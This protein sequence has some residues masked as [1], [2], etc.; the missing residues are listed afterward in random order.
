MNIFNARFRRHAF[1]SSTS[2]PKIFLFF[3][4]F[5]MSTLGSSTPTEPKATGQLQQTARFSHSQ[6]TKQ[7]IFDTW[8]KSLFQLS[9]TG[10]LI[11]EIKDGNKR[12]YK[13]KEGRYEFSRAF[14]STRTA[15]VIM[16]P[17]AD[18]GS[19]KLNRF[20][21]K[22]FRERL[23]PAVN[24]AL[25]LGF[26]VIVLTND[27]KRHDLAYGAEISQPLMR[28]VKKGE[29]SILYHIDHDDRTFEK[30]LKSRHIES[31]IYVG[32]ASNMCVIGMPMG[33][34]P[35]FHRGF[36]LFYI[37]EASAAFEFGDSWDTGNVHRQ[38]TSLIS[39]WVAEIINFQDFIKVKP[40]VD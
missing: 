33:M 40:L 32:F 24:H 37:P 6:S 27:P 15:L 31:L 19:L 20:Y 26:S 38:T 18:S 9:D 11:P 39:Q 1:L 13:I 28:L 21:E 8:K 4:A 2:H 3:V 12:F 5:W 36:K 23:L 30:Y 29:I 7:Y 34:I 25:K 17:W 14:V 16:D 22:V 35:M 10:D